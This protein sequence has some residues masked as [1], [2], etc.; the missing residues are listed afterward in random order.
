MDPLTSKVSEALSRYSMLNPGTRLGVA[1][2]GGADSVCLLRVLSSLHQRLTVIHV[3]HHLRGAESDADERFVVELAAGLQLTTMT[4]PVHLTGGG[5]L[6]EEAREAR[7]RVFRSLIEGGVVDRIALAHTRSDQAETVLFRLLRGAYVTGLA[8][9]RPVTGDGLI[10][11]MLEVTRSEVEAWL[12]ERG[13]EFRRD[14]S[15]R[16]MR[17]AR[18]RIRHELLPQLQ[19]DWNPAI[20]DILANHAWLAQDDEDYWDRV[21]R[22]RVPAPSEGAIILDIRALPAEP[23]VQRRVLREAIRRVKGDLRQVD[24]RHIEQVAALTKAGDGHGR[25]QIPGVDVMRS[26]DW[27][28]FVVPTEQPV[29][30]DWEAAVRVPGLAAIAGGTE[31]VFQLHDT[32]VADG[33]HWPRI[34]ESGQSMLVRNWRP[35]DRYQPAGHVH[36]E[37]VKTMFHDAR[38]PLWERRGWPVV[39]LGNEIVWSRRFGPAAGFAAVTASGTVLSISERKRIGA[40]LESVSRSV[41]ES[42]P[43]EQ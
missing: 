37:K 18:N 2:S 25:V 26:F 20:A 5:N 17:F 19:R 41:G 9:M 32:L 40:K 39:C 36:E 15:N 43:A 21:V 42:G 30:R 6:E 24:Y 35:G 34:A 31:L 12:A 38:I 23:A 10:R 22:E 3:N 33:I 27:L 16:D 7:R 8:G 28:R 1:V 14:S 11:P 29:E 13:G 4:F